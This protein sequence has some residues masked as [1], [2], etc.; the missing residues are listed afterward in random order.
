[1]RGLKRQIEGHAAANVPGAVS[2]RT[3]RLL[4]AVRRLV[5]LLL[6]LLFLIQ[7]LFDDFVLAFIDFPIP[8]VHVRRRHR[9]GCS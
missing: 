7:Q 9:H 8:F 1:M 4:A 5:L 3:W 6:L 2:S